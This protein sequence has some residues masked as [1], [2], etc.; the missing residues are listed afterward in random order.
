MAIAV[1][2][3]PEMEG[4]MPDEQQSRCIRHIR[5]WHFPCVSPYKL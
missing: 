4:N 3:I 2:T 1:T 5:E